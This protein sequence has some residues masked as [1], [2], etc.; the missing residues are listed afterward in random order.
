MAA[1][2]RDR[3]RQRLTLDVTAGLMAEKLN[4]PLSAIVANA[5]AG[6]ELLR[7]TPPDLLETHAALGDIVTEGRRAGDIIRSIRTILAAVGHAKGVVDIGVIVSEALALLRME[8]QA[9]EVSVQ[10]Q[11]EPF[12]RRVRGNREQLRQV[13]LDLITNAIESMAEV[14]DR[15]RSLCVACSSVPEGVSITVQDSGAGIDPSHAMRLF[16]PLFTTKSGATGL[17]L[18]ICRSIV[19]S[20]GGEI[21]ATSVAP[22]GS[23]FRVVLPTCAV[24]A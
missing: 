21:F 8:L 6:V 1:Q 16:D 13:L 12:L 17:G 5:E 4:Q 2:D 18:P 7:R 3:E 20:H 19:E 23:L 11:M 9:H 10:V 15:E 22:H 24:H 14:A